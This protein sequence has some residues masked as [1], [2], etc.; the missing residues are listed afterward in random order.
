[1]LGEGVT[2]SQLPVECGI[3]GNC[4][5]NEVCILDEEMD[6]GFKCLEEQ[7]TEIRFRG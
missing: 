7:N 4:E 1:M 2:C 5:V 6:E 3:N